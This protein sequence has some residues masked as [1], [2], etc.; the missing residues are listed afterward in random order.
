GSWAAPIADVR[1]N[2]NLHSV[3]G[4]GVRNTGTGSFVQIA[5]TVPTALDDYSSDTQGRA[6]FSPHFVTLG[7]DLGHARHSLRGTAEAPAW[8]HGHALEGQDL[9]RQL[10][11]DPEEYA[12]I[13]G[14]ENLIRAE[15][16]LPERR[17]HATIRS[18]RATTHRFHLQAALDRL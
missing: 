5:P 2:Q 16:G 17:Y 10:W 3:R 15:Q 11:T 1:H 6:L 7:H 12:N 14:E 9:E 8:F 4:G 18:G 13:R